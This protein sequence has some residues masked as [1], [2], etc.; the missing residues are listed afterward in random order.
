MEIE[1]DISGI[2]RSEI[3]ETL[4]ELAYLTNTKDLIEDLLVT[5]KESEYMNHDAGQYDIP[6]H[7]IILNRRLIKQLTNRDQEFDEW[8]DYF[9]YIL[10]HEYHHA[11]ASK[12]GKT[13]W[14]P[15]TTEYHLEALV[16]GCLYSGL[17]MKTLY[18]YMFEFY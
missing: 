14:T 10:A 13:M 17:S 3:Q 15:N 9:R 8:V 5:S 16:F 1:R 11:I 7:E 2:A 12:L 6:N 18:Q 4:D